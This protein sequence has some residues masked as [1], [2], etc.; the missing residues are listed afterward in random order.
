MNVIGTNKRT[1]EEIII[2]EG[3][4]AEAAERFCEEWGWTYTDEDGVSYWLG[5][6]EKG[7]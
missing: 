1:K 7:D 5:T 4:T 3:L 6:S 2:E